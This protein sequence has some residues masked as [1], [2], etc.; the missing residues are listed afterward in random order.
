MVGGWRAGSLYEPGHVLIIPGT[1]ELLA[2]LLTWQ[3]QAISVPSHRCRLQLPA[4]CLT[5]QAA[6]A[7]LRGGSNLAVIVPLPE[8]GALEGRGG[9]GQQL[10][11][12][13]VGHLSNMGGGWGGCGWEGG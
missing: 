12:G 9:V 10:V 13:L 7:A 6:A 2:C 11:N 1:Q 5:K 8:E 4:P 3:V